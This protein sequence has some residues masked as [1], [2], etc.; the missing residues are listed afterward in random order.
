MKV[1]V[2]DLF[3]VGL[4]HCSRDPKVWKNANVKLKLGPTTLLIHLKIILLQY[5]QFSVFNNKLYSNRPLEF[6]WNVMK[7]LAYLSF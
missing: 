4:M 5:F 1:G 2:F 3:F 7:S 6:V